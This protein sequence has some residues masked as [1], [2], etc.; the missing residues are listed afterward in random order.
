MLH[1]V[2]DVAGG[3]GDAELVSVL[4]LELG[5]ED[6][7]K[8]LAGDRGIRRDRNLQDLARRLVDDLLPGYDVMRDDVPTP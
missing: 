7:A 2:S 1:P 8:L 3:A 6:G 4:G 5:V